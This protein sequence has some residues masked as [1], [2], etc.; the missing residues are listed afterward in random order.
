M[1]ARRGLIVSMVVAAG[2]VAVPGTAFADG[3]GHDSSWG[4]G[5]GENWQQQPASPRQQ[6]QPPADAPGTAAPAPAPTAVATSA[7]VPSVPAGAAA[8][9]TTC[10][11][12]AGLPT[13]VA[14]TVVDTVST[15]QGTVTGVTGPLPVDP[16][17]TVA[18]QLGC[19]SATQPTPEPSATESTPTDSG[20]GSSGVEPVSSSGLPEASSA[21]A[22][23][24]TPAFT[25]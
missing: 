1:H 15:V 19:T 18:G 4:S 22:V 14:A 20:S 23:E 3:W 11:T 8:A 13:P 17:G 24:A 25:G 6:A 21:A 10:S 12:D 16:A 9:G 7:S 2:V 5:Q